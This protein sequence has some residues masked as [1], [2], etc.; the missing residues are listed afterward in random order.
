MYHSEPVPPG[1]TVLV[2]DDLLIYLV[3]ELRECADQR[4]F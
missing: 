2:D 1:T 4:L 3:K